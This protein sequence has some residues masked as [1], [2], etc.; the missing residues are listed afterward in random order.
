[1]SE[2]AANS[3]KEALEDYAQPRERFRNPQEVLARYNRALMSYKELSFSTGDVRT[4][5][6]M[7]YNE[8]KVLR[9]GSKHRSRDCHRHR[10]D[11]NQHKRLQS[12]E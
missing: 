7:T 10:C 6:L 5:K 9:E 11:A 3:L 2:M 12:T 4:Q 8:I 1:M